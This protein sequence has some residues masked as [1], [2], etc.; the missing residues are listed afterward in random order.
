MIKEEKIE[1]KIE[2]ENYFKS[3][4]NSIHSLDLEN[5]DSCCAEVEFEVGNFFK[6]QGKIER[7]IEYYT[8]AIT[9]KKKEKFFFTR[10]TTNYYLFEKT[11]DERYLN[12]ALKD[13]DESLILCKELHEQEKR[14]SLRG[15]IY[16]AMK[17]YQEALEDFQRAYKIQQ[18]ED[19]LLDVEKAKKYIQKES[20]QSVKL[21]DSN[22]LKK[23]TKNPE[24]M[25]ELSDPVIRRVFER[26]KK[27]PYKIRIYLQ[28]ERFKRLMDKIT[29][30]V[31]K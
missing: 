10:G 18:S 23:I 1:P 19:N 14:F 30:E 22:N 16:F 25:E 24:I 15:N 7:S 29:K 3:I 6:Q 4:N 21:P 8:K 28:N 9:L 27:Y 20:Y 5:L 12:H 13:L 17:K 31:E 2:I 26:I 11:N